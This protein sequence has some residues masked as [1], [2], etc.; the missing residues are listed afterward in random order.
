MISEFDIGV[1]NDEIV[2]LKDVKLV[3]N[4]YGYCLNLT[5]RVE[6]S[7][8]IRDFNI[9]CMCLPIVHNRFKIRTERDGYYEDYTANVG[10]GDMKMMP[11]GIGGAG[12]RYTI[13]TVKTKTK[14]MTLDEIEKKLGHKVKIVNK[15][16]TKKKKEYDLEDLLP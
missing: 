3:K 8:E 10:L 9:P 1:K 13:T 12:P 14:E 7:T 4:S 16:P 6:D 11:S 5:Y 15:K 2:E